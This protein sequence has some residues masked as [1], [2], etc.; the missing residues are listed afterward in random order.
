[1]TAEHAEYLGERLYFTGK[2][3]R[4][5]HLS[6]RYTSS[7]NCVECI[8]ER[9]G[10]SIRNK[11]GRSSVRNAEDQAAAEAALMLG[12]KFYTSKKMCP[13]GHNKRRVS[14]NNCV[15]CEEECNRKRRDA[16][17]WARYKKLYNISADDFHRMMESQDGLCAICD[18]ELSS[19]HTH[20][21][22]CH[23][24]GV[25]R[26][27]LCSRCNQAIGLMDEDMSRLDK[28]KKYLA[29]FCHAA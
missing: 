2:K 24:T 1:M 17:R 11:R 5:G 3:C 9:R 16:V 12:E 7:S 8:E 10:I 15:V 27:L 26:G 4:H 20:V 14:T 29:R 21:D 25:V 6:P 13:N 22:H 28:A 18:S 19:V 23:D